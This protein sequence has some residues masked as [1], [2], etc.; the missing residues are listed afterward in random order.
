[1][2]LLDIFKNSNSD[3]DNSKGA[4][5]YTYWPRNFG[6]RRAPNCGHKWKKRG[7]KIFFNYC[8]V[9]QR[10]FEQ[11]VN[12]F[13]CEFDLIITYFVPKPLKKYI[14]DNAEFFLCFSEFFSQ[15]CR[16]A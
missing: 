9:F 3:S 8:W 13:Y 11:K 16:E 7:L 12:F 5:K 4:A 1:M 14:C 2:K 15:I 6:G 10:Q